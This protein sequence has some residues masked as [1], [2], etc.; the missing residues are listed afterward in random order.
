VEGEFGRFGLGKCLCNPLRACPAINE[1][2]R[3]NER[4]LT[5]CDAR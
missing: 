3:E 4:F 1:W 5:N 2:L